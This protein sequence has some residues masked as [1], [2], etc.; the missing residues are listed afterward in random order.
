MPRF[1][2]F[3]A[4]GVLATTACAG[5]DD[6]IAD[7]QLH[8]EAAP[9]APKLSHP[10][11][12]VHGFAA[13][14]SSFAGFS[15]D[16]VKKLADQW[17]S[18]MVFEANLPAFQPPE[19]RAKVLREQIIKQFGEDARVNIIA[20]SMGGL[21]ARFLASP[22]TELHWGSH[23]E[24]IT[25]ISTPHLGS[26]IAPV[27]RKAF[28]GEKTSTALNKV[29]EHL[30]AVIG[31]ESK[32]SDILATLD[33]LSPDQARGFDAKIEDDENVTYYSWAG[34]SDVPL[35]NPNPND[36]SACTPSFPNNHHLFADGRGAD[37]TRDVMTP[38]LVPT[39]G[40]VSGS[41]S[42]NPNAGA[43]H[44][45]LVRVESA[46]HGKFMG[47]IAADHADEVGAVNPQMS[48]TGYDPLDF[49]GRLTA[50]LAHRKH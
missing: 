35:A 1:S 40:T 18:N 26:A 48:S 32:K 39:A 30:G 38:I 31:D 9:E 7:G 46:K 34:V 21:D 27:L 23:I 20:H 36:K 22:K 28:T 13:T 17:G 12:L 45:G 14:S 10:I 19:K 41:K 43:P 33:A 44:D 4:L 3:F 50:D 15:K 49:Y 25:T 47:C 16:V 37:F 29:L 2:F 8:Q 24:S 6:S 5:S 42:V 11:V